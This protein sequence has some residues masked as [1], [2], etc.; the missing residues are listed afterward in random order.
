MDVHPPNHAIHSWKD[1]LIHLLT[2]TIGLFIALTL[3]A[4]VEAMHHRHLVRNARA[5]LQREI[6]ANQTLYASNE[7]RIQENREQLQRDIAQLRLLATGKTTVKSSLGWGWQWDSYSGAVWRASRDSGA[8]SYMNP[9]LISSY[10]WIYLQQDYINSTALEI[11]NEETKAGAALEIAGDPANLTP[12]QIEALLIKTAEIDLSFGI[13]Q[14]TM[15]S[16]EV[17]Y[18]DQLQQAQL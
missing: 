4:A 3:E 11:V 18:K 2:I 14:T 8:V 1:F 13:L 5:N 10:S 17:M 16:L 6:T 15:K 12:A 9:D 7:R